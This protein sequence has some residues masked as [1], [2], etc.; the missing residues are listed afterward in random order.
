MF[1]KALILP[2]GD[3]IYQGI[4]LDTDSPM[5]MQYL[6]RLNPLAQVMRHQPLT[7]DEVQIMEVV[8]SAKQDLV[9]IIGGSGGGHRYSSTLSKDYTHSALAQVLTP[10]YAKE[11]YGKNGHMW[12]KLVCG[13]MG[14]TL[15]INVPG[16]F[17][18]A[19]A[20]MKAF[21]EAY[22]KDPSNLKEINQAMFEAVVAQYPMGALSQDDVN[23]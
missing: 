16:P 12:C 11:I 7:D 17:R 4:V 3:E 19:E 10:Q 20:A 13:K 23:A 22:A 8:Q 9:I 2:T 5:L 6:L 14:V 18:E 15:V 21:A 1:Q